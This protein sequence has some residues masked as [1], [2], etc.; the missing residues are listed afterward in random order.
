MARLLQNNTKD[1]TED[2]FQ[3]SNRED[4]IR[5]LHWG[6]Q[7]VIKYL[8]KNDQLKPERNCKR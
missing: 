7:N 4:V 8:L 6:G 2:G 1:D 5:T 3:L